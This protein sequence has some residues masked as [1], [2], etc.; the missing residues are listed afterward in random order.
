MKLLIIEDNS[1][2]VAN[3]HDFLVPRGYVLDTAR[4]AASGL[5]LAATERFDAIVIDVMLPGGMDGFALCSK[6]RK[7][8]RQTTPVLML[9]ARSSVEDKLLGFDSGA[10]DYLI[11]P[12]SMAELDARVKSLVRRAGGGHSFQRLKVGELTFDLSTFELRR[13]GISLEL[14]PTG[15]KLL[16]CLMR[17]APNVVRREQLETAVWG[18]EPPQSDALRTHLHSL[19]QAIDKP[20]SWPMLKTIAGVGYRLMD[21]P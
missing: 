10:D 17:A 8:L 5:L 19:R 20:F 15:Y 12:F 2:I 21:A 3:L 18:E 11:K 13:T 9:T 1:D 16:S 7:E 6:I 4:T 14:T